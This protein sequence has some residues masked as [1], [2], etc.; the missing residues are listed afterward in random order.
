ML[1]SLQGEVVGA[2]IDALT[3][4]SRETISLDE[5]I[6]LAGAETIPAVSGRGSSQ[7][8]INIKLLAE[9]L[10]SLQAEQR[11]KKFRDT[12]G[13]GW[14]QGSVRYT[15]MHNVAG[16]KN[17]ISVSQAKVVVTGEL[18]QVLY[19][20]ALD[21]LTEDTV[22]VTRVDFA[23]DVRLG[24]SDR[25]FLQKTYILLSEKQK[26]KGKFLAS[27]TGQTLYMGSRRSP[28]FLRV[29][30][31]SATYEAPL[32]SVYRYEVEA[33][34]VSA[35]RLIEGLD[36]NAKDVKGYII[37]SVGKTV[38]SFGLSFPI[39]PLS[40]VA[41]V[42]DCKIEVIT[43]T[44]RLYWLQK[45]ALPAVKRALDDNKTGQLVFDALELDRFF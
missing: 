21:I 43:D 9:G 25:D 26:G 12:Y 13:S 39:Y 5:T 18:S 31:K 34:R 10:A 1:L 15:F 16:Q 22:K 11:R 45:I 40:D 8:K 33:K 2:G 3:I 20:N 29:Y 35:A 19:D 4:V 41:A 6:L 23:C 42:E 37:D 27:K 28:I 17:T 30:D 14:S 38:R 44:A 36:A 32:G 24:I 7:D